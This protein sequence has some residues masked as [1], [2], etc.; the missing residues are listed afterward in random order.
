MNVR[1]EILQAYVQSRAAMTAHLEEIDKNRKIYP[2]W[3]IREIIAHLSGWDDASFGML[4]ALIKGETPHTPAMRG[5]TVYNEETVSTREGL[6]YDHILR[7]YMSTRER[8]LDLVRS[9]PE[10]VLTQITTL[11]WGDES[12]FEIMAKF[13][14]SHELEHAEDVRKLIE[15][16]SQEQ[17]QS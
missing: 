2:L 1:E 8:L 12:S 6:S 4:T 11:P 14:A 17:G 9:A 15:E 3:T 16:G 10:E 5:A 13:L 7:E